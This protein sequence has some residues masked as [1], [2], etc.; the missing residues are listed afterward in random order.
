MDFLANLTPYFLQDQYFQF[1]FYFLF[2]FF[3]HPSH[4]QFYFYISSPYSYYWPFHLLLLLLHGLLIFTVCSSS[5]SCLF[6]FSLSSRNFPQLSYSQFR[7]LSL[8]MCFLFSFQGLLLHVTVYSL[9]SYCVL[10]A[11]L[12][13]FYPLELELIIIIHPDVFFF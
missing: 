8:T 3:I 13:A 2:S 4:N 6:V 9:S 12:N 11:V 5:Y 1:I 7:N 10:S